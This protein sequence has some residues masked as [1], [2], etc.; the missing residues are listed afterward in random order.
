MDSFPPELL[1]DEGGGV[2]V[3]LIHDPVVF[4][5]QNDLGAQALEGLGEL[6]AEGPGPHDG[7][8]TRQLSEG[9]DGFHW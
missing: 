8:S 2:S 9:K 7:Q 5:E 3:L 6:A 4:V 1:L